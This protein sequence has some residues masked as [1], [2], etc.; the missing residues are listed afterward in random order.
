[1]TSGCAFASSI[2][3]GSPEANTGSQHLLKERLAERAF[4]LACPGLRQA[5]VALEELP[6]PAKSYQGNWS[7]EGLGGYACQP[8]KR[9]LGCG[10]GQMHTIV[11]ACREAAD[12][13]E[14][15]KSRIGDNRTEQLIKAQAGEQRSSSRSGVR[16]LS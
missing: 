10:I 16:T 11:V 8:V 13:L 15:H 7:T 1:M 2:R 9:L 14:T 5:P 4:P 3:R 12:F 6:A